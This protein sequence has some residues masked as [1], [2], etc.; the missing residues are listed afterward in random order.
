[1][2]EKLCQK[3][4]RIKQPTNYIVPGLMRTL[5]VV[6]ELFSKTS[7]LILFFDGPFT[8]LIRR[9]FLRRKRFLQVLL[10]TLRIL[11]MAFPSSGFTDLFSFLTCQNHFCYDIAHHDYGRYSPVSATYFQH[12][13][14]STFKRHCRQF[15]MLGKRS[16][17]S[18]QIFSAVRYDTFR[19]I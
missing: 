10:Q 17:A 14:T 6:C 1:M 11:E 9:R 13:M 2:H 18:F 8:L 5:L 12:L 16:T 19:T 15:A 3:G 7:F 4:G